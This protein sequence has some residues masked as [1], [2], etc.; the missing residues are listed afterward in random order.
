MNNKP[1]NFD[2]I[3]DYKPPNFDPPVVMQENEDTKAIDEQRKYL[4]EV[5]K[6]YIDILEKKLGKKSTIPEKK[7]K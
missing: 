7:T 2:L 3:M 6:K 5:S 4:E 1:T